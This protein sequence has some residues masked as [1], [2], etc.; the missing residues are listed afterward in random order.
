[1]DDGVA[2]TAFI[3]GVIFT[4]VFYIMA[5]V[6]TDKHEFHRCVEAVGD[7]K[8]CDFVVSGTKWENVK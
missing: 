3:I 5:F 2:G 7:T 8:I 6:I 1:M 4:T